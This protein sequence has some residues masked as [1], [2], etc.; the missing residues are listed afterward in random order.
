MAFSEHPVFVKPSEDVPL[1]RFMDFPKYYYLMTKKLLYFSNLERLT[2]D[3]WEGLPSRKIFDPDR[4][5][6]VNVLKDQ[7]RID[8][9]KD[10]KSQ[11]VMKQVE[12]YGGTEQFGRHVQQMME[13]HRRERKNYFVSCWHMNEAESEALWRI[14]GGS[15]YGISIKSNY[16]R[17]EESLS[18]A[19]QMY[20]G[21]VSYIDE[22][23]EMLGDDNAFYNCM[24][25]RKSFSHE[26]EF[27]IV[28][29]E[30]DIDATGIDMMVN[31]DTLVDEIIVH[32]SADPWFLGIVEDLTRSVECRATVRRSALLS[33]P[34]Y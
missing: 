16:L 15:G 33:E 23:S 8:I 3:P 7:P 11:K 19:G 18:Y 17:L 21:T 30:R 22:T 10:V 14:Y 9:F 27:R 29:Y 5:I 20:A 13:I 2:N 6:M 25:K 24:W 12:F 28:L 4:E 31:L 1:W 34:D 26:L 32:P